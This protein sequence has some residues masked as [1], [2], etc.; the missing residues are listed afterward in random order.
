MDLAVAERVDVLA[1]RDHEGGLAWALEGQGRHAGEDLAGGDAQV[2]DDADPLAVGIDYGV[3][4][5]LGQVDHACSFGTSRMAF[6]HAC[7]RALRAHPVTPLA[8]DSDWSTLRRVIDCEVEASSRP[9][10]LGCRSCGQSRPTPHRILHALAPKCRTVAQSLGKSRESP[11]S[12]MRPRRPSRQVPCHHSQC[13][14][15][16]LHLCREVRGHVPCGHHAREGG[17]NGFSR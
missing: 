13:R 11:K 3:A 12:R 6:G 1:P 5:Q 10:L 15:A 17:T 16:R 9:F 14:C 7:W 8:A 4:Q 2:V